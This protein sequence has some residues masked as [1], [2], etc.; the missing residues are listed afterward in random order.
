LLIIFLEFIGEPNKKC[1]REG[2]VSFFLNFSFSDSGCYLTNPD[3]HS[4]RS[5]ESLL[6]NDGGGNTHFGRVGQSRR[7]KK[8]LNPLYQVAIGKPANFAG[9]YFHLMQGVKPDRVNSR[10]LRSRPPAE[11]GT[12]IRA[13]MPC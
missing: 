13:A 4:E 6:A 7:M 3:C 9:L 1:G 8:L 2:R 5:E 10:L 11:E 12:A